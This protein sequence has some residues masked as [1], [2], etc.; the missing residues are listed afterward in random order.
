MSHTKGLQQRGVGRP[1]NG[2]APPCTCAHAHT[3]V[4]VRAARACV[5][6]CRRGNQ[7]APRLG[8]HTNVTDSYYKMAEKMALAIRS[9]LDFDIFLQVCSTVLTVLLCMAA[10]HLSPVF[11]SPTCMMC[12]CVQ[13]T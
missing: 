2:R 1:C 4:R 6:A 5:C 8:V 7:P 9:D 10:V 11:S 3:R 12:V 13:H